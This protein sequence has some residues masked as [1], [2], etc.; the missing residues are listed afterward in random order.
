MGLKPEN[1]PQL[2][3]NNGMKIPCIG[4]GTFGSD[5][6]SPDDV[7]GAVAGALRCGYRLVDCAACYGNE[8]QI[9]QVFADAFKEGVCKREELFVMTK[10]WNDM[11]RQVEKSCDQSIA[12]LQC[13]YL[14]ILFIHWPFPNYHAPFCDVDSRNPDSKPFS[15]AEFMDTYRQIEALVKK[16]KVRAIGISNLT[17]PK[18]EQVIDLFEIKPVVCELELHPCFQ[19]QELFDWLT[20]HDIQPVGF[21]PLGSPRRPERDIVAEDIEDMK[22]PE[23]VA[24]A[25]AHG[26][27]PA[28]ICLKWA[29][30]RGQLP[31]P[32]SVHNYEGNLECIAK[33][34]LSD[35]EMKIIAGMEKNNR[36]VKGQVFLWPGAKD[37]HDLWDEDGFIVD[38]PDAK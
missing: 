15:I 20:A 1:V 10:V 9:G 28:A 34:P 26:V 2:T 19:Q 22:E 6:V 5:R 21:M 3:L 31:I 12:D 13:D 14:D 37:W 11:H 36:L 8:K 30:Q 24:I 25:K 23:L 4:V 29:V 18:L 35:E 17:I 7:A 27:H 33:D 32:F 16:G 38:C